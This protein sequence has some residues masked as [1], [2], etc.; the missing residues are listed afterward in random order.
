MA[1]KNIKN[2]KENLQDIGG[3]NTSGSNRNKIAFGVVPADSYSLGD[4]L[5]F[6]LDMAKVIEGRFNTHEGE[7]TTLEILPGTNL[8][9]PLQLKL[10]KPVDISYVVHY[11]KGGCGHMATDEAFQGTLQEGERLKIHI[12]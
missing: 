12:T 1:V 2:Y 7:P 9:H 6:N 4:L 10:A 5:C 8:T 11:V 3:L